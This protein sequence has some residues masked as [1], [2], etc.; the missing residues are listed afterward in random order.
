MINHPHNEEEE[1]L[2]I[3]D[4][5]GMVSEMSAGDENEEMATP[6]NMGY[7]EYIP[8]IRQICE[9]QPMR[10]T[11]P[12]EEM[13]IETRS[14][15]ESTQATLTPA[16]GRLNSQVDLLSERTGVLEQMYGNCN[17]VLPIIEGRLGE[18][19]HGIQTLG[20]HTQAAL[21]Q[22]ETEVRKM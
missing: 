2:G 1:A 16:V 6:P 11:S 19:N 10:N 14:L 18:T 22:T 3:L 13:Y 7:G 5:Q 9:V 8:P 4:S 12:L 20:Q 15:V 17:R 21:S